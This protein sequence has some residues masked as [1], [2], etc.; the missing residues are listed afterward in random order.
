MRPLLPV[1]PDAAAAKAIPANSAS[2]DLEDMMYAPP[3]GAPDI[4][5]AG[6]DDPSPATPSA[7]ACSTPSRWSTHPA[8]P[9]AATPAADVP[10]S[11]R[12]ASPRTPN[13]PSDRAFCDGWT[14]F[15]PPG[16]FASAY[17]LTVCVMR[18]SGVRC[19]TRYSGESAR[20]GTRAHGDPGHSTWLPLR[21]HFLTHV[22]G[23]RSHASLGWRSASARHP[24]FVVDCGRTV[25]LGGP[26]DKARSH[27]P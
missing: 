16:T 18:G 19:A 22:S 7:Y 2:G 25:K 4:R 24:Q 6:A 26:N 27:Y 8:G 10:A 21:I 23:V 13:H 1:R 3:R 15:G 20:G 9:C 12:C 14:R 11:L 17:P 5:S